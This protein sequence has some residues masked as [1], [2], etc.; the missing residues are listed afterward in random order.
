MAFI[1]GINKECG[2]FINRLDSEGRVFNTSQAKR[3]K[4]FIRRFFRG[5][6]RGYLKDVSGFYLKYYDVSNIDCLEDQLDSYRD[7]YINLD[8]FEFDKEYYELSV[9]R[10]YPGFKELLELI[11]L[12]NY[13]LKEESPSIRFDSDT[14]SYSESDSDSDGDSDSD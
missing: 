13:K 4:Y 3:I 6:E 5:Q 12:L 9:D 1:R 14:G 8:S 7:K 11:T 2:E 10:D